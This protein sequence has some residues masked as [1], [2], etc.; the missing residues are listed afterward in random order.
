MYYS[1][2][3]RVKKKTTSRRTI[4]IAENAKKIE[5]RSKMSGSRVY[6]RNSYGG[7]QTDGLKRGLR[8]RASELRTTG[9]LRM[10][11]KKGLGG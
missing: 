9:K 3:R 4:K 10:P 8:E 1:K 6:I 2:N 11:F 7:P 5:G